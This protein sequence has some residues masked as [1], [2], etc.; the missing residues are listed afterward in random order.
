MQRGR[1]IKRWIDCFLRKWLIK[2]LYL[3]CWSLKKNVK[4]FFGSFNNAMGLALSRY[5][6][7][8]RWT[9][10][11]L[12][13][14]VWKLSQISDSSSQQ[15]Q[16]S[17]STH[18]YLHTKPTALSMSTSNRKRSTDSQPQHLHHKQPHSLDLEYQMTSRFYWCE[19]VWIHAGQKHTQVW[20]LLTF[21]KPSL[22]GKQQPNSSNGWRTRAIAQLSNNRILWKKSYIFSLVIVIVT[23]LNKTSAAD[24]YD[25]NMSINVVS[26]VYWPVLL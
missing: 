18:T 3:S 12:Y 25:T 9:K 20:P 21:S 8:Y 11:I 4:K 22:C 10:P 23:S 6:Q 17:S 1:R 26:R 5:V 14:R 7:K 13:E 15:K 2:V 19:L 16:D 24:D